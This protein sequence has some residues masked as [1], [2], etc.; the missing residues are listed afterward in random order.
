MSGRPGLVS[1]S[2]SSLERI[3]DG[4]HTKRL[5][6]PITRARLIAFGIKEQIPSLVSV[7]EGHSRLACLSIVDT[8]L[9]ERAN[10]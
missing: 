7:F 4:L 10:A 6:A 3:R 9:A 2:T 1:V 5:A 8:A